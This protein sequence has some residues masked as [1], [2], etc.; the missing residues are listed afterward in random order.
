MG[1]NDQKFQFIIPHDQERIRLDVFLTSRFDKISRSRLQKLIENG[2][3]TVNNVPTKASYS[4]H[5]DDIID[6]FFPEPEPSDIIAENI[7]LAIV[8][9]DEHLL[10]VDKEA[11][12][13][14]HPAYG[15]MSGTLVN[16]LMYH[17]EN[18]SGIGGV[19]R[20]GIVHR[21]DKGTSGLLV[22]AKNDYAHQFLSAQFSERTAEREY[23]A[24]I[25]GHFREKKGKITG[26]IARSSRDR[27][28]M[29]S[30]QH[31][32]KE[33]V[34]NFSVLDEYPST[35]LLSLKL[36]TGRTHQIRVHLSAKGHPVLGDK[37][38]GGRSKQLKSLNQ[39][40]QKL[41]LNLL[42]IMPRQALHARTLGF[43]HPETGLR[44]RFDSELP[45]DMRNLIRYLERAKNDI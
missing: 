20:P 18:L 3:I 41:M 34:T 4:L 19:M 11:S 23:R 44:L 5:S 37:A 42:R 38:Y 21:L 8:Y 33:A 12:M 9:E 36:E 2:H 16:A 43:T 26:R 15:N 45:L 6:I 22:V 24:V 14:V 27:T 17:C 7:E 25:C 30:T 31:R 1:N 28:K 13:V 32:G 10:V 35:S 39:E 40:K 29:I